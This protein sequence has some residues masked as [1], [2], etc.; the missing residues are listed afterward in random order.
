MP[1]SRRHDGFDAFATLAQPH[2]E[3]LSQ[4]MHPMLSASSAWLELNARLLHSAA[5]SSKVWLDFLGRRLARNAVLAHELSMAQSP[6]AIMNTFS[7]FFQNATTDYQKEMTTMAHL[8]TKAAAGATDAVKSA[9]QSI[10]SS[11][12]AG[13]DTRS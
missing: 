3:M 12:S 4:M 5:E 2:P 6:Q 11:V 1:S 13:Q 10:T 7:N 9:T 8:S